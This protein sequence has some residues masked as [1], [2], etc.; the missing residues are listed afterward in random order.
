MGGGDSTQVRNRKLWPDG[1]FANSFNFSL[2]LSGALP[3]PGLQEEAEPEISKMCKS[4][5]LLQDQTP[6]RHQL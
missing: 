3:H 1:T 6:P 2:M 5:Y 4:L